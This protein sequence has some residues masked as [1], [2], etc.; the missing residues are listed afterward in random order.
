MLKKVYTFAVLV[1]IFSLFMGCSKSVLFSKLD[2]ER[3]LELSIV[4]TKKAQIDDKNSKVYIV[5]TY[6]N[7]LKIDIVDKNR[8]VF[9]VGVYINKKDERKRV[10]NNPFYKFYLNNDSTIEKLEPLKKGST[11]LKL[12]PL[13]SKWSEYYLVEFP[14]KKSKNLTL[15]FENSSGS[16]VQ[17]NFAKEL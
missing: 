11:Y 9:L 6:L 1:A 17:L 16:R 12:S 5:V 10:Q 13:V 15:T 8:E 2:K 4:N 14:Y 3:A 7:P